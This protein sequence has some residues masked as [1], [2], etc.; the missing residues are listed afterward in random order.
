MLLMLPGIV[1]LVRPVQPG[2]VFELQDYYDH[3]AKYVGVFDQYLPHL[4][5]LVNGIFWTPRYPRLVTIEA[6]RTL[7][8]GGATP[9]LKVIGD[10]SC[11]P[12][13]SI[14]VTV[15][16]TDPGNPVY[17]Y[18]VDRGAA[19]DGFAGRGPVLLAVEIL[20]AELPRES[21][22]AFSN[23]LVG[24]LPGLANSDPSGDFADW[25][26]PD[27]LKRAVILHRGK[28][29]EKFA[30]VQEYLDRVG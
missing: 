25:R 7:Y 1:T 23:A 9:R 15:K 28:L 22:E 16:A 27:P 6:L 12:E 29:T 8:A 3:P 4:T 10:I 24:L 18:D 20:P 14:E 26:L 2:A 19:V 17:V 13:G 5:M 21:S 11:D 30:G